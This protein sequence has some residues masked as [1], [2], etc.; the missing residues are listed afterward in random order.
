MKPTLTTLPTELQ[1]L[2]LSYTPLSTQ[3]IARKVCPL[4]SSLINTQSLLKTRYVPTFT[5]TGGLPNLHRLLDY[6]GRLRFFISISDGG[7]VVVKHRFLLNP[8]SNNRYP[9][10]YP[11]PKSYRLEEEKEEEK[12]EEEEEEEEEIWEEITNHPFLSEPLFSPFITYLS[13][14]EAEERSYGPRVNMVLDNFF[15]DAYVLDYHRTWD[16]FHQH[17]SQLEEKDMV[18]LSVADGATVGDVIGRIAKLMEV[19]SHPAAGGGG[20]GDGDGDGE[21]EG[22]YEAVLTH[23]W[24]AR[25]RRWIGVMT[26]RFVIPPPPPSP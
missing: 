16:P 14:K 22:V 12:K 9:N 17:P 4:W 10:P 26:G 2:I 11:Y 15:V 3:L 1:S 8:K 6:S 24:R 21:G 18:S 7:G 5:P 23:G 13:Q 19:R 20:G 25:Q